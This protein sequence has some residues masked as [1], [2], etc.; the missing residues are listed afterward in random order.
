[1]TASFAPA[2]IELHQGTEASDVVLWLKTPYAFAWS[3]DLSTFP[4]SGISSLDHYTKVVE[5][6]DNKYKYVLPSVMLFRA[7]YNTIQ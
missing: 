7:L 1:M 2:I 4:P 3:T 5:A 6:H